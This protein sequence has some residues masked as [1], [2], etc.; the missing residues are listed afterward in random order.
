M[1]RAEAPSF[2]AAGRLVEHF[3]AAGL[4]QPTLFCETLVGGGVYAPHYA[5]L[6]ELTRT[7]L[8]QIIESGLATAE[9]VAID[10]LEGRLRSAVVEARSQIEGPAQIC[11]WARV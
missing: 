10:T 3:F 7:L 2:G 9:M 11:A 1:F 8:P 4:A 6:A 5:W